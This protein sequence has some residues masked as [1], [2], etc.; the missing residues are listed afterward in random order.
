MSVAS[1]AG[2]TLRRF[3]CTRIEPLEP[4]L[5]S[6]ARLRLRALSARLVLPFRSASLHSRFAPESSAAHADNSGA[7]LLGLKLKLDTV[8][9][10]VCVDRVSRKCVLCRVY[11]CVPRLP[12]ARVFRSFS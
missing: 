2:R 9:C 3:F 4:N 10:V 6:L 8:V 7:L 11:R 1:V 5:L 12:C